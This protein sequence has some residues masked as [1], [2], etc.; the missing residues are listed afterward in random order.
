MGERRGQGKTVSRGG[1]QGILTVPLS[2]ICLCDFHIG[3]AFEEGGRVKAEKPASCMS[4]VS[5]RPV[6][7]V[8]D[9]TDEAKAKK[10]T[11]G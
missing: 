6:R 1:N 11:D 7:R 9:V 5:P 4:H 8:S 10:R 2:L 3:A